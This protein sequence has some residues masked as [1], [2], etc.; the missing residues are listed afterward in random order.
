MKKFLARKPWLLCAVLLLPFNAFAVGV[1]DQLN[2]M[3]GDMTN[4]TDPGVYN[5]QRRGVITGGSVVNRSRIMQENILSFQPPSFS[6][7][8]GGMDMNMGSFSFIN[9]DQFIQ[10]LR[11]VASNAKGYAFSLALSTMCVE[12]QSTIETMQKK[13]Q[14]LNEMFSNS[15]QLAQ[16]IVND[17]AGS[18]HKAEQTSAS[19]R[20]STAGFG[21]IFQTWTNNN[22]AG[23]SPT[24]SL[25]NTDPDYVAS[26]LTGNLVWR[27]LITHNTNTWFIQ[28]GDVQLLEAIMSVS[29]SIIIKPIDTA[30]SEDSYPMTYLAGNKIEIKDLIDGGTVKIYHCQDN[31]NINGCMNVV[32]QDVNL[33]GIRSM[34]TDLLI[35]DSVTGSVGVVNMY[36]TNVGTLTDA[37]KSLLAALP[38][39]MGGMIRTLSMKNPVLA[40]DFIIQMIP[41]I[42]YNIAYNTITEFLKTVETASTTL[43]NPHEKDMQNRIAEARK[44]MMAKAQLYATTNAVDIARVMEAYN[45]VL[46]AS[47]HKSFSLARGTV[48][49]R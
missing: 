25:Q 37:Q 9:T 45:A 35:A 34:L 15:C 43:Q 3:F 11:A 26:Q 2:S 38:Q 39:G 42:A 16:G 20:A 28:N 14:K 27:Q 23:T 17:S 49:Q 4:I 22:T 44:T 21:D 19:I 10:M 47:E 46:Q 40:Q 41:G 32:N 33:K 8:C 29:G 1:Q 7:G 5:G 12:C 36:A 18:W 30:T 31:Y 48:T 6:A 24:V 13:I